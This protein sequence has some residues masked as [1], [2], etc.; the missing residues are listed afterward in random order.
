MSDELLYLAQWAFK[1]ESVC[2]EPLIF[3]GHN[4]SEKDIHQGSDKE[5]ETRGDVMIQYLW[6]WQAEAIIDIK[7]G[8]AD[9]DS[10]KYDT[11]VALLAW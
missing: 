11:M 3:Q 4:R 9:A 10:Y 8:N 2:V 6:Y 1:T 5:K 7:F